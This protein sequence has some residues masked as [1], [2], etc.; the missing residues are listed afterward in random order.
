MLKKRMKKK[1]GNDDDNVCASQQ[2]R[3]EDAA[4]ETRDYMRRARGNQPS[5]HSTQSLPHN[6]NKIATERNNNIVFLLFK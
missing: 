4:R 3:T 2:G 5:R 1:K 6:G